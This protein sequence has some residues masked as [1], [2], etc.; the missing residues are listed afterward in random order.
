MIGIQLEGENDFLETAKD[1]SIS[2]KLENPIFFDPDKISPGSYS[3]PFDIP[4]G[5]SSQINS[6]KL[7]NPDVLENNEVFVPLRA[8]IFYDGVP[9]KRGKINLQEVINKKLRTYFTF[10]LNTISDTFKTAKLRDAISEAITINS[11][12]VVRRVYTDAIFANIIVNNNTQVVYHQYRVAGLSSFVYYKSFPP[13]EISTPVPYMYKEDVAP[14]PFNR[15][16]EP[17]WVIRLVTFQYIDDF[18]FGP[19]LTP[20]DWTD[21]HTPLDVQ[22]TQDATTLPFTIQPEI[23]GYYEG[24]E[25]WLEPYL[26]GTL[27]ITDPKKYLRFPTIAATK[28]NEYREGKLVN[29]SDGHGSIVYN[30]PEQ[31][32]YEGVPNPG[33]INS[34]QPFINL[35]GVLVK[36]AEHFDFEYEGDFWEDERLD[37]TLV[38][39][40]TA[41]D[42]PQQYVQNQYFCFWRRE[43]NLN[44]LVPDIT[45]VE[46]FKLLQ[47]VDSFNLAVYY[48][49]RTRK[50]RLKY[51]ENIVTSIA[52]NDITSK[53]SP[54]KSIIPVA[55]SPGNAIK[56]LTATYKSINLSAL[57]VAIDPINTLITNETSPGADN[58]SIEVA[59]F[60][61]IDLYEFSINGGSWQDSNVFSGLTTGIYIIKARLEADPTFEDESPFSL[62]HGDTNF[63][64]NT[65]VTGESS[66]GAADGSITVNTDDD[67]TDHTYSKDGGATWQ[68][69]FNFINLSPGVYYVAVRDE[70]NNAIVRAVSVD[71]NYSVTDITTGVPEFDYTQSDSFDLQVLKY[72]GLNTLDSYTYPFIS[73]YVFPTSPIWD[74]MS[75]RML[76]VKL[77]L[78]LDLIDILN[79]DWELKRRFD[80]TNF[81]YKSLDLKLTNTG[82]KVIQVELYT[83]R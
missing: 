24:F 20:V 34:I 66:P 25:S 48:N 79:L 61:S 22:V 77:D 35:R 73:L 8:S 50:V 41:L 7:K 15:I 45:V 76:S 71:E 42:L 59:T 53:A 83:L 75:E 4:G 27:P 55:L 14:S 13:G 18:V 51:R 38:W 78:S 70:N 56:S 19:V 30:T 67:W 63:D 1:T 10:G 9:F 32:Y 21:P 36:I 40:T 52:Y 31:R 54:I 80:R 44:E 72:E 57:N 2:L 64:F 12:P 33:N 47:S 28:L 5:D 26:H 11:D 69:P 37:Y 39:N 17:H 46:F 74:K 29:H 60:R 3:L 49:E 62:N 81:L 6:A 82:I 58:G 23:S 16:T 68:S 65:V 43:F